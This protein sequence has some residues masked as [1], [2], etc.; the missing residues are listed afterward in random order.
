MALQTRRPRSATSGNQSRSSPPDVRHSTAKRLRHR[1]VLVLL[2]V[3]VLPSVV[4]AKPPEPAPA[5]TITL[6]ISGPFAQRGG[7]LDVL[8]IFYNKTDDPIDLGPTHAL[9]NALQR[10]L[11][12]QDQKGDVY[13]L[14]RY[15]KDAVPGPLGRK[16]VVLDKNEVR[17]FSLTLQLTHDEHSDYRFVGHGRLGVA[18]PDAGLLRLPAGPYKLQAHYRYE[19][20]KAGKGVEVAVDSQVV[21]IHIR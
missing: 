15:T 3:L 1:V 13:R 19:P 16:P 10:N 4:T 17:D 7:S 14:Q 6:S 18:A 9:H 12:F 11:T 5:L 2:C 8:V 21:D 20:A